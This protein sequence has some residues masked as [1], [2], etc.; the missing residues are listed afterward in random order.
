[1]WSKDYQWHYRENLKL[2]YPVILSQ[3]GHILVNL[4]DSVMVGQL[5]TVQLAAA[6]LANSI[7]VVILVF[8]LGLSYSITPLVAAAAGNRNSSRLSLLLVNGT[9][10][11]GIFGLVLAA[12]GYFGSP[13]LRYLN[14]PENVVELA[15][16]FISI[17]FLSMFPLM[18][19][20][21]FKQFAEGLAL[22]KQAMLISVFAN[23]LNFA[24]NYGLIFGKL[25]LPEIGMNGAAIATLI[26]RTL[27]AIIIGFYVLKAPVYKKYSRHFRLDY[28]SF[29]HMQ[30]LVKIGF[31]ISL[32]MLF[33]VGA[34]SFSAV[35][36]GWLG[37]KQL[38]AHQIAISIA[39]VTY[40]MASGIGAA[41]TIRVGTEAGKRN[42]HLVQRAGYSNFVLAIIFMSVSALLLIL[43]HNQIP[44]WYTTT[45]PDPDV[46]KLAAGL[47]VIAAIFQLSDGV[48]VVG[49][50]I[51]R[52]LEDVKI[53]G[54]ISLLA[55]W[56]VALP[57]GYVLG[58]VFGMGAYG[59][60]SGLLIGLTIAAGLLFWR[61]RKLSA[62]S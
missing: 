18:I 56:L 38:A 59:V 44:V 41:G 45:N 10:L 46:I 1:M 52:G 60:W 25:G 62:P 40:M 53:P 20:Q 8:G 5:G 49:L 16:P 61:F 19:F 6:S 37:A 34:F 7:F 31:P 39:S 13:L 24:L 11:C 23:V 27:M 17:L 30:R 32:Q 22:T 51:L 28:L 47:L 43:F 57:I 3:L 35:M 21:G 54:L 26:S 14:Q 42:Y 9:V 4:C 2:A 50:G 36:I 29:G 55:Y 15:I 33:E 58:F 12:L 48:Q